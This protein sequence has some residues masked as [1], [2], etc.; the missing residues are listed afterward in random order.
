[1][2]AQERGNALTF[3]P[4]ASLATFS[5]EETNKMTGTA[6]GGELSYRF[7]TSKNATRWM[8]MINLKSIDFIFNYKNM[9]DVRRLTTN[10]TGDSG[11]SYALLVGLSIPLASYKNIHLDFSPALG[12]NYVTKTWFTNQNPII[13]SHVN[14]TS[15]AAL[16]LTAAVSNDISITAGLDVFHYSNGGTRVPNN[17]MNMLNLGVGITKHFI[18]RETAAISSSSTLDYRTHTFDVGINSGKRGV[19]QSKDNSFKTGLYAGYNYRINP[20]LAIGTGIDMVYYHTIYDPLRHNETYQSTGTSY[21]RWRVGAAIGP[22]LWMG[23]LAAGV[24]YGYYLH[25]NSYMPI[26]TYWTAALKYRITSWGALQVKTYL[27]HTEA[28]Y[29]GF[30]FLLSRGL[31]QRTKT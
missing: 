26:N 16:N 5:S 30:G 9:Y 23:R 13:S 28:D 25:Y 1:M 8:R 3:T 6:Y 2:Y 17:G 14:L 29:I 4:N 18:K 12:L 20:I 15:K 22:D 31:V 11:D 21:E 27:H 24:K 10:A 7:N 19:Y